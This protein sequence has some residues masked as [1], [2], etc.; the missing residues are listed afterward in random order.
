M[1]SLS[2]KVAIGQDTRVSEFALKSLRRDPIPAQPQG[3]NTQVAGELHDHIIPSLVAVE[4]HL[5]ALRAGGTVSAADLDVVLSHLHSGITDLRDLME[6]LLPAG[7][8]PEHLPDALAMACRRFQ[9]DSSAIRV[10][11]LADHDA[12]KLDPFTCHQLLRITQEALVNV[13]R[14]ARARHVVVRLRLED[15][16]WRLS[17]QDDGNGFQFDGLWSLEALERERRGPLVIKE[18]VHSI[19]SADMFIESS[20][21][22]GARIEVIVPRRQA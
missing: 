21:G 3:S 6:G 14:H 12:V 18:R 17:I 20:R 1:S 15:D 10:E 11:F 19:P 9:R 5:A 2:H 8:A 22:R 13:R 4:M 7:V 16:V